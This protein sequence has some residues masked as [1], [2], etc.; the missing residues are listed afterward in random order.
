[1]KKLIRD[2]QFIYSEYFLDIK[3]IE[4]KFAQAKNYEDLLYDLSTHY[5]NLACNIFILT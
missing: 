4:K 1:M 5:L 2:T 3:Y